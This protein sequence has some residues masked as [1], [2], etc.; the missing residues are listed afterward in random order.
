MADLLNAIAN[1]RAAML[2]RGYDPL[3]IEIGPRIA[4]D[5]KRVY[6]DRVLEG[7]H[8]QS[9]LQN[10]PLILRPDMEGFAILPVEGA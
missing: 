5:L 8:G 7:P 4:A 9:E 10:M 3:R 1:A 6:G 2:M